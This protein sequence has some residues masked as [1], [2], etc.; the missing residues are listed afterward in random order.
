[1]ISD[2]VNQLLNDGHVTEFAFA[3]LVQN[4][5]SYN[6]LKFNSLFWGFY[7]PHPPHKKKKPRKGKTH[8]AAICSSTES[9]VGMLLLILHY[10][11]VAED[12]LY[13]YFL[14]LHEG[15]G[16]NWTCSL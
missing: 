9:A 13:G 4:P 11:E 10:V 12:R 6:V 2:E 3:E 14:I 5:T 8:A 1:M 15:A 16:R 7:H